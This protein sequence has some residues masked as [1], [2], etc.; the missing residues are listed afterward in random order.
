[1]LR[2]N[3]NAFYMVQPSW[4]GLPWAWSELSAVFRD[5]FGLGRLPQD[6]KW[7][8]LGYESGADKFELID[9]PSGNGIIR[10]ICTKP[11]QEVRYLW[12]IVLLQN[13]SDFGGVNLP[14]LPG[15]PPSV[16][17]YGVCFIE[18]KRSAETRLGLRKPQRTFLPRIT[19]DFA[20]CPDGTV[21]ASL[22]FQRLS[23]GQVDELVG[24]IFE[25]RCQEFGLKCQPLALTNRT[26]PETATQMASPFV[27]HRWFVLELVGEDL[28]L[29]AAQMFYL[30]CAAKQ[31]SKQ[32]QF[33]HLVG[34]FEGSPSMARLCH[35]PDGTALYSIAHKVVHPHKTSA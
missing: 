5:P 14:A 31:E 16:T 35:R 24:V 17:E 8:A 19:L 25:Q 32:L 22:A 6:P 1:M 4:A 9:G 26:L 27:C 29:L 30:A 20:E 10:V 33:V 18:E 34:A 12:I 2:R 21:F 11:F 13:R 3:P 7:A 28:G 23:S 15:F